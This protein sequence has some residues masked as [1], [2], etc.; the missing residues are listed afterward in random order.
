[1][2]EL[3]NMLFKGENPFAIFRGCFAYFCVDTENDSLTRGDMYREIF[4]FY[5]GC[6]QQYVDDQTTHV[7]SF[8]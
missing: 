8:V 7:I 1:M 4:K 6:E 3:D 5:G 2:I